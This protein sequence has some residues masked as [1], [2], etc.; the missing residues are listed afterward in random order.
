MYKGVSIYIYIYVHME[1]LKNL[2]DSFGK[3]AGNHKYCSLATFD[4][5]KTL[6][7][8]KVLSALSIRLS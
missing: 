6:A 3:T 2:S 4:N 1:M 7:D 5:L 8:C